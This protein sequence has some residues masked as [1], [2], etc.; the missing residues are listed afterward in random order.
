V[1]WLENC[2]VIWSSYLCHGGRFCGGVS[3]RGR[4]Y[5]GLQLF[6]GG[7]FCCLVVPNGSVRS[8]KLICGG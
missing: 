4:Y 6:P 1:W 2:L 5:G 3:M 8:G 7:V